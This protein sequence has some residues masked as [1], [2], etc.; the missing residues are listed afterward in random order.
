MRPVLGFY[1]QDALEFDVSKHYRQLVAA[2]ID[3]A[4][5][6]WYGGVNTGSEAVEL[7]SIIEKYWNIFDKQN[8]LEKRNLKFAIIMEFGNKNISERLEFVKAIYNRFDRDVLKVDG[9]PVLA[10]G[11]DGV[12]DAGDSAFNLARAAGFYVISSQDAAGGGGAFVGI[13]MQQF[14]PHRITPLAAV[15]S[16][17]IDVSGKDPLLDSA[18]LESYN[19]DSPTDDFKPVIEGSKSCNVS[20]MMVPVPFS[21]AYGL[22]HLILYR[23]SRKDTN[24]CGFVQTCE[25]ETNSK[26][27]GASLLI[28]LTFTERAA[29]CEINLGCEPKLYAGGARSNLDH[30]LAIQKSFRCRI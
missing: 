4:L 23:K 11:F 6:S 25:G 26:C 24:G 13:T 29:G 18:K 3:F 5:F 17:G 19:C 22:A 8:R 9:K 15:V 21:P 28:D 1:A 10:L 16:P 20:S 7:D 2:N 12:Q 30:F 14:D 27:F